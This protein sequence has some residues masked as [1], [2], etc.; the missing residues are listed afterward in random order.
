MATVR[1]VEVAMRANTSDFTKKMSAVEKR[2]KSMGS[3][4]G[5]IAASAARFGLV[6]GGIATGALV[7]W[8]RNSAKALD[9]VAK[10]SDQLGAATE[11]LLALEY[12]ASISGVQVESLHRSLQF[13]NKSLGEAT[14]GIG[15]A[16]YGL[17]ELGLTA[18]D[19]VGKPTWDQVRIIAERF[20]SLESQQKKAFVATKLFGRAGADLTNLLQ[21]G[22]DELERF[23]EEAERM[24]IL[25]SREELAKVEAANDAMERMGRILNSVGQTI[26]V[27][28]SPYIESI[29]NAFTD[30]AGSAGGLGTIVVNAI[31]SMTMGLLEMISRLER[32]KWLGE[33]IEAVY[34]FGAAP[35]MAAR[36]ATDTRTWDEMEA[37][38]SKGTID[39][40]NAF[41]KIRND[42]AKNAAEVADR[43]K[44]VGENLNE[45]LEKTGQVAKTAA[46]S[47]FQLLDGIIIKGQNAADV[48]RSLLQSIASMGLRYGV[49][50]AFG[51][52]KPV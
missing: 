40:I 41:Q 50:A 29:A 32:I 9:R 7:L 37:D 47:V 18:E 16:V 13:L 10:L 6:L 4:F 44:G 27:E 36:G 52:E 49:N 28:L 39:L 42:A 45:E 25:F 43:L 21:L 12:A 26:T 19:L 31:E 51:V 2:L 38:R 46:D 8:I 35:R 23:R 5:G 34:R 15:E 3:F 17:E 22:G 24:G 20:K 48:M 33:K 30:W 14:T 1:R 11:D